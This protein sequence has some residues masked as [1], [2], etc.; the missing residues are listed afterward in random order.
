M[1]HMIFAAALV[2]AGTN[3][4]A[5]EML[6]GP[7]T[8]HIL[9]V[10]D[11]DTV[12]ARVHIWLGQDLTARI[13]LRGIDAPELHGPCPAQAQAARDH[14]ARL[15]GS[16]P[17]VLTRI[18]HDKFGGRLDADIALP[19]GQDAS[20]AMIAAGHARPWPHPKDDGCVAR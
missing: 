19:N 12:E 2:A 6:A 4:C 5:S 15:L 13:R 18:G 16:G 8:A 10:V 20:S 17:V 9:R 3:A 7:Y 11:G 14:L 1:R